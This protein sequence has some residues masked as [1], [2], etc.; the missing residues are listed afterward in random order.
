MTPVLTCVAPAY[1]CGRLH[2]PDPQLQAPRGRCSFGALGPADTRRPGPLAAFLDRCALHRGWGTRVSA[3]HEEGQFHSL[4][5]RGPGLS[6]AALLPSSHRGAGLTL[7]AGLAAV[8]GQLARLPA[9]Q[10]WAL[11]FDVLAAD[12]ARAPCAATPLRLLAEKTGKPS[13]GKTLLVRL[14]GEPGGGTEP[15]QGLPTG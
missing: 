9:G 5:P 14:K 3:G 12:P 8:S 11:G 13:E 6:I 15:G 10:G 1:P 2:A 7:G 4:H